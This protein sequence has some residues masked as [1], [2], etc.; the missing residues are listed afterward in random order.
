M[1]EKLHQRLDRY[2]LNAAMALDPTIGQNAKLPGDSISIQGRIRVREVP[3]SS[4]EEW[5][6]WWL[7]E[8]QIID[9]VKKMIRAPRMSER[10]KERYTAAES[11]NILVD[12]GITQILTFVGSASGN[13]TAFAEY[14]AFG[15]GALSAVS[16]SDTSLA[17][18][19][20]RIVP[21]LSNISGVQLNISAFHAGGGSS[22][23][24]TNAGLFGNG[25][26]GTLG[27]G[28]MMTHSLL[29]YTQ[30]AATTQIPSVVYDYLLSYS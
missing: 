30:P 2:R 21:T 15:N 18:E 11:T 10:Q 3:F 7:G 24:L 17:N 19:I 9:G 6:Y 23:V 20:F 25:A 4:E 22:T 14:L 27:S 5:R 8:F 1:N 13:S 16:P 12:G 29:S 26:S 28:T